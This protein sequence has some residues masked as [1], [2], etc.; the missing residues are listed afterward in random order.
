MQDGREIEFNDRVQDNIRE[1][2][3]CVHFIVTARK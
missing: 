2:L 1:W 3:L